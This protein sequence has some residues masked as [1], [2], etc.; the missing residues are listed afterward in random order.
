MLGL[1]ASKCAKTLASNVSSL[2][3][4]SKGFMNE[5]FY[6][7]LYQNKKIKVFFFSNEKLMGE[8]ET[9]LNQGHH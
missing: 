8:G 1:S 7:F 6:I 4:R 2:F 9:L 3:L 5:F